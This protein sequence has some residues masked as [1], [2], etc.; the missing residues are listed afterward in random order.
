LWDF[1][2]IAK[3]L[4]LGNFVLSIGA[5]ILIL[6]L[7]ATDGIIAAL[8]RARG[9]TVDEEKLAVQAESQVAGFAGKTLFASAVSAQQPPR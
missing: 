6:T 4:T 2:K 8:N 1:V 9:T 3:V 5:N 7:I